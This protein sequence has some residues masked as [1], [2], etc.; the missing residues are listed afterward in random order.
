MRHLK[1]VLAVL[2]A[3]AVLVLAANT[4]ALATTGHSLLLGSSNSASTIT[5]LTR[6]TSGT[7]L[8]VTTHSAS[9][10][11]L[12]VNG[13]GKVTNLNADLL[14]GYD[15]S[16]MRNRTYAFTVPVSAGISGFAATAPLPVGSYTFG[17]SAFLNTT[18]TAGTSS[19][20]VRLVHGSAN[21]FFGISEN[22]ENA[23]NNP[24][25]SATGELTVHTG[26]GV[27]FE[28]FA[29]TNFTSFQTIPIQIAFTSTTLAAS[30]TISPGPLP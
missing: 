23:A 13:K 28:C 5:A 21:T 12:A 9:N 8:K 4:V 7:A 27:T 30:S 6:T 19:C 15:S 16:T 25:L 10:A 20:Q 22:T 17:Y 14:D 18:G 1:T 3:T 11:P 24:A 2:G 26:D 29:P